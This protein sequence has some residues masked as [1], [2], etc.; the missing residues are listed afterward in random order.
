[1]GKFK[2]IQWEINGLTTPCDT[3]IRKW[4]PE[5]IQKNGAFSEKPYE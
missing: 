4:I 1:M 3:K 5:T 2:K